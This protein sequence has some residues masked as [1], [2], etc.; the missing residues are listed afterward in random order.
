VLDYRRVPLLLAN[1]QHG[2]NAIQNCIEILS[3]HSRIDYYCKKKKQT[4]NVGKDI[5]KKGPYTLLVGMQVS[6]VTMEIKTKILEK[7]KNKTI[8]NCSITTLGI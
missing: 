2:V 7:I 8:K 4:T 1:V 3:H 6:I 5:G